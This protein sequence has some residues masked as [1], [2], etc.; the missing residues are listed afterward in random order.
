LN[1]LICDDSLEDANELN[2]LLHNSNSQLHS[3]VFYNSYDALNHAATGA[4]IDVCI[5]DIIMPKMDGIK[6]AKELR[7]GGF[8]GEI[9]FLSSS[10]EFAPESYEVKAF[11]YLL[12]PPTCESVN[13][14]LEQLEHARQNADSAKML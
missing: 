8:R 7:S 6:L 9:V 14:I 13:S 5:L 12:K 10:R 11:S 3:V 4:E 2:R 1:I